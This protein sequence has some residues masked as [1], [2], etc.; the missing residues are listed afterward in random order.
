MTM[1]LDERVARSRRAKA[2]LDDPILTEILKTLA[3]RAISEW[4]DSNSTDAALRER[5][6][7]RVKAIQAL[8]DE[9]A[10]VARDSAVHEFN[11]KGKK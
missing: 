4:V 11:A 3:D 9:L 7:Q 6:W 10:S 5:S 2:L 8:R 1:T